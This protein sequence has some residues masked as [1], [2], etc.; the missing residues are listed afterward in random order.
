MLLRN[1][2]FNDC[3]AY[4]PQESEKAFHQKGYFLTAIGGGSTGDVQVN[5]TSYCRPVK[6]AYRNLEIQLMLD[7]LRMD[8]KRVPSSSRDQ[9]NGHF[10]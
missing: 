5:D 6:P 4:L 8:P 1:V 10:S 2:T 3:S 9:N 7:R